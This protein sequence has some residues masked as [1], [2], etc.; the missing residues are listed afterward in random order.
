MAV[1][2]KLVETA[3]VS[4]QHFGG[5]LVDRRRTALA[6]VDGQCNWPRQH[7]QE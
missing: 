1:M 4:S 2:R 3:Y 6:M 7:E 5:I